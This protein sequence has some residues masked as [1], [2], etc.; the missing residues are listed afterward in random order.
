[1]ADHPEF[2]N[3][4]AYKAMIDHH[5]SKLSKVMDDGG[6]IVP[7]SKGLD[8]LC[9]AIKMTREMIKYVDRET[10]LEVHQCAEIKQALCTRNT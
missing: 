1:M 9:S 4:S 6:D 8:S 7:Y 10:L 3:V 5:I 2:L